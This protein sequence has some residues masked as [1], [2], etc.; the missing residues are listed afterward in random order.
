MRFIEGTSCAVGTRVQ[1]RKSQ[2]EYARGRDATAYTT[3]L[4]ARNVRDRKYG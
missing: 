4:S 2:K 3:S 1:C